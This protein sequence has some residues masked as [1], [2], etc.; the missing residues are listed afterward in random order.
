MAYCPAFATLQGTLFLCTE[1]TVVR[2]ASHSPEDT[3]TASPS[4]STP[5]GERKKWGKGGEDRGWTREAHQLVM[6]ESVQYKMAG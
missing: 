4:R 3:W 5:L 2:L 6:Y 1:R